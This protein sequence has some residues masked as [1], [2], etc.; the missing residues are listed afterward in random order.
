MDVG[1]KCKFRQPVKMTC[2]ICPAGT[3]S[4]AVGTSICTSCSEGT[5]NANPGATSES[6][7]TTCS[8]GILAE[9]Q[10]Y[11]VCGKGS[12]GD[13]SGQMSI[14][15]GRLQDGTGARIRDSDDNSPTFEIEGVV[16]GRL[17]VKPSGKTIWGTISGTTISG[18]NWDDNDALVA[19]R[20]IAEET[21]YFL[22]DGTAV[23]E[24]N[25]PTGSG[26]VFWENV[27]C[28]GNEVTLESCSKEP[29]TSNHHP[30]DVGI[31]CKFRRAD[32]CQEC[33]AGKFSDIVGFKPCSKCAGGRYSSLTSADSSA[34]CLACGAGK[35]SNE[36]SASCTRC[37][38]SYST[39][40]GSY[41]VRSCEERGDELGMR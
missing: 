10:S 17:E 16:R 34:T 21:G 9:D 4:D 13:R 11:C 30:L 35:A 27:G 37:L 32:E 5:A 12:G 24:D 7:C 33:P 40:E 26:E 6:D 1:I 3:Y 19:C 39:A 23:S 36:G 25:A 8:S 41:K 14:A 18:G 28:S 31:T 15:T 22:V 29:A 2:A 38:G 20:Q